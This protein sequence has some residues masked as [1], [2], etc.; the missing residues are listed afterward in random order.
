MYEIAG[1]KKLTPTMSPVYP[2][3]KWTKERRDD[4]KKRN[5]NRVK[6]ISILARNIPKRNPDIRGSGEK[7]NAPQRKVHNTDRGFSSVK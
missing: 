6:Q 7:E 2:E 1:P 4:T 5:L 3:R